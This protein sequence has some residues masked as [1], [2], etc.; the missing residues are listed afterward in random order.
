MKVAGRAV[1]L[2]PRPGRRHARATVAAA[3]TVVVT[4]VS[5]AC[6]V[7]D[8]GITVIDPEELPP[9]LRGVTTTSSPPTEDGV[10]AVAAVHWIRDRRLVREAVLFES[11]P[12]AERLLA[13]LERGPVGSSPGDG[14]RSALSAGDVSVRSHDRGVV[15]VELRD[16]DDPDQV[17]A[18]GQV[19]LTLTSLPGVDAVRF[20]SR[21]APVEVPLP[22]GTLVARDLTEGDYE[23][24]LDASPGTS[25]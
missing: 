19:V 4:V 17:L 24:L 25:R 12:S 10:P 8:A 16:L 9:E 6:G 2:P 13:L 14:A 20:T 18:V 22:D 7:P 5:A 3:A 21:G 11:G 23:S 1:P 15:T